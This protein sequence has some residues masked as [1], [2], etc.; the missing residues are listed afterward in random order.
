MTTYYSDLCTSANG[1]QTKYSVN[2]T[3]SVIGTYTVAA[4]L[5]QGDVF[6]M[7]PVPK[8]ATVIGGWLKTTDLD[9]GSP[10]L[11]LDVGTDD[12]GVPAGTADPDAFIDGAT[13]GQAG[14][15]AAFNAAAGAGF[16]FAADGTV[17]VL[18]ATGPGTGA[19]SGTIKVC[20]QYT[21]DAA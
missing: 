10:A 2:G 19:T 18:V 17:D 11:V 8:G 13:V 12:V 3:V 6:K 20:V 16:V 9:T 15:Y 14:G 5:V 1:I 21:M 7:V 4:A